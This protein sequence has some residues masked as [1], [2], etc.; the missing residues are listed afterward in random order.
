MHLLREREIELL[1]AST[2]SMCLYSYSSRRL[3]EVVCFAR[4]VKTQFLQTNSSLP[5]TSVTLSG[6]V[7]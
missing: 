4:E 5:P 1:V 7:L 3:V 2:N 6:L